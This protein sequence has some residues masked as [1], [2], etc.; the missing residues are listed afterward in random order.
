MQTLPPYDG[1]TLFKTKQM[2]VLRNP[3]NY[4]KKSMHLVRQHK[5][6]RNKILMAKKIKPRTKQVEQQ[7]HN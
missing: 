3:G 1:T 5:H 2:N 6:K 4:P 7:S